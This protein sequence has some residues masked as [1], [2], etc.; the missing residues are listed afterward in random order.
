M[1]F[2]RWNSPEVQAQNLAFTVISTENS[3]LL[4]VSRLIS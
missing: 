3:I 1:W 4:I 2:I